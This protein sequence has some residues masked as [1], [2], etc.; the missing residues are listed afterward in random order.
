MRWGS[1]TMPTMRTLSVVHAGARERLARIRADMPVEDASGERFGR[2][3]D[4][5]LDP[6]TGGLTPAGAHQAPN[7]PV[8]FAERLHQIGYIRIE[9][10][11]YF[12]RDF[13]YYATPDQVSSVDAAVVRLDRHCREL[14]TA[15]D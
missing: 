10:T 15:F 2:V 13:R 7:L 12:R 3:T 5:R 9:D 1:G 14:I 8:E 4:V 11:R 6:A